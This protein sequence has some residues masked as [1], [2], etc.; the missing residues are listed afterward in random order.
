[1]KKTILIIIT[2]LMA[3]G[4]IQAQQRD[5][6]VDL[7]VECGRKASVA[8]DGSIWICTMCGDVYK[9][10]GIGTSWRTLMKKKDIWSDIHLECVVPFDRNTAVTM[11]F[12]E[13]LLRTSTGDTVWERIPY[14]SMKRQEWFHP[15]WRGE[16]GRMWAGSQDGLLLFSADSGRTFTTLRD[17]AFERKQGIDDIYM[18][19]ADSGWI[20]GHG[21]RI[22]STTDN[23]RTVRRW[24]TPLDQKLYTVTNPHDQYW[25]TCVRSWQ[26]HLLVH[27]AYWS[28]ITPLGDTLHWQR[29]PFNLQNDFEVDT[30]T[31]CLWARDSVGHMVVFFS[32]QRWKT[33]D[34]QAMQIAGIHQGRAYCLTAWGVV[35][36][37]TAGRM[38][39]CGFYTEERTLEEAFDEME[40]GYEAYGYTPH[41][42]FTHS[43]HQWRYDYNS[44]YLKDEK[45]WYRIAKSLGISAMHP[46][47]DREDRV[48]ILRGEKNYSV[49]TAG[50]IESY[51]YH[52]PLTRFL[53]SGLQGVQITTYYTGCFHHEDH[54]I[55]YTRDGDRLRET[56]NTID[57]NRWVSRHF[58]A[59][60]LERALM[61]L[62]EA[63]S[64]FPTPADFGLQEGDVDLEKALLYD[65]YGCTSGAG[66]NILFVNGKGDTLQA[67]GSSN[68]ECGDYFPWMLPM[69]FAGSHMDFVTYQPLL[70]Q[71]LRPMMPKGMMLRDFL[72]NNS[73]IDLRPGDLLFFSEEGAMDNAIKAST[74]QY[75][76][77][78]MVESLGQRDTVWIIDATQKHGVS[79]RPYIFKIDNHPD[80]YRVDFRAAFYADDAIRRARSFIGQPYDNAFLPDNGAL[81]CSEL[82]YECYRDIADSDTHLFESKPMNWRDANGKL[83]DYW[84]KHFK[85][86]GIPVPEGVPGTNPTDLSRST[87]LQ[88]Q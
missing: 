64:L 71:A 82:I 35:A 13:Y 39:T 41:R 38:D 12:K 1:M 60:T 55:A 81:Y 43:G 72:S 6:R 66:Y 68:E 10:D 3:A 4:Q 21:N 50:R 87:L 25:V 27:E 36:I 28:F 51:T 48:I 42:G 2:T 24:A 26:N 30:A 77:V 45:G 18:L 84:K 32:P 74:G 49:D 5:R 78:A 23:W 47:P 14:E 20:A 37:D 59:D 83:P 69:R 46:D 11:G 73:L 79:R 80:V 17:T 85:E 88:K 58:P 22:Y 75:T 15:G 70:W 56:K 19:S 9:A 76:H 63:Y 40:K 65:P 54:T 16:G 52:Q 29:T 86:L 7:E 62:G 33:F 31:G 53:E 34:L 57:S 61:R 8:P 44:V 67:Y